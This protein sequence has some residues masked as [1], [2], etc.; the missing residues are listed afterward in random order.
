M[1]GVPI[2]LCTCLVPSSPVPLCTFNSVMI[3]QKGVEFKSSDPPLGGNVMGVEVSSSLGIG[4]ASL[5]T[6][7]LVPGG[8][9]LLVSWVLSA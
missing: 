8:L 1:A 6:S 5:P 9:L 2:G 7:F 4:H 3:L